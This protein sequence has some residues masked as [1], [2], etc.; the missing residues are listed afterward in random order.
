ME[1]FLASPAKG[2]FRFGAFELRTQT[3]ELLKHG[4]RIRLQTK[5]LQLLRALLESPGELITR[6]QLC[7]RLWPSGTFVDF[8]GGLNTAANRLRAAL[9]DCAE[10]PRYIETLPRLGYRFIC[11]VVELHEPR[12]I[13]NSAPP[14]ALEREQAGRW[15]EKPAR[16]KRFGLAAA[17]LSFAV[18]AGFPLYFKVEARSRIAQPAFRQL[19]FQAG[20]LASARFAPDFK[21][22]VYTVISASA[23]QQTY[24]VSLDGSNSHPVNSIPESPQAI[25][26]EGGTESVVEFP[27]GHRVYAST[28]RITDLRVSPHGDQLAFVEHP[29]RDD[30][31][32]HIRIVNRAGKIRRLPQE[33]NS[34]MGLAWVPSG[35]EVWFTASPKGALMALYAVSGNGRL[36]QVSDSPSSLR[37]FDI[38]PHGE[39]LISVEDSRTALAAK[40]QGSPAE[41]DISYLD[42]SHIDD[43]SADGQSLL[44]TEGGD[45]GGEHYSAFMFDSQ[46]HHF[47]RI[48]AGRALALSPD[49]R[50][51]L[52]IDPRDRTSLT[53][54]LLRTG[55]TQRIHGNGF[56]YQW[57]R[58]LPD[59]N[60]LLV[61]GNFSGGPLRICRQNIAGGVPTPIEGVPYMEYVQAS[62]D[63]SKVAGITGNRL[64]VYDLEMK[65][66]IGNVGGF[67]LPVGWSRD[68]GA[69]FVWKG[70]GEPLGFVRVN[71]KTGAEVPWPNSNSSLTPRFTHLAGAVAAPGV[72]AYAYSYDVNSSRLYVVNGWL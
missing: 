61:G 37:L 23:Q 19:S 46:S 60:S 6:E 27:P 22:A 3:G 17:L 29:V 16:K 31:G 50:A 9:G 67:G 35:T 53:M 12:K 2:V 72:S 25:I 7:S 28:G 58:F 39:V 47:S 1:Q 36:R 44:F 56:E 63:G 43:I 38:S 21:S 33:W 15:T 32:G 62:P 45:G 68:G 54:T 69:L 8:E 11:P 52:T 18:L 71:L 20:T 49:K 41:E 48:A 59:M 65:A 13:Q 55:V 66:R 51:A 57:A 70:T 24:G 34:V 4:A 64:V 14:A 26:R 5:P 30:S 10:S 42:N 40:L